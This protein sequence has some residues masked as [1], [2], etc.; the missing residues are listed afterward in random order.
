LALACNRNWTFIF[1]TFGEFVGVNFYLSMWTISCSQLLGDVCSSK[2]LLVE[3]EK[4]KNSRTP[5]RHTST[6]ALSHTRTRHTQAHTPCT[7]PWAATH[8]THAHTPCTCTH[9]THTPHA[10]HRRHTHAQHTM[11]ITRT[12]H[13]VQ[14]KKLKA[15]YHFS[16]SELLSQ[17]NT[18]PQLQRESTAPRWSCKLVELLLQSWFG[19]VGALLNTP[20]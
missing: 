8:Y 13:I 17:P 14:G 19:G 9:C 7:H 16:E 11:H 6:H 15:H 1:L 2:S 10:M 12:T 18:S 3:I 4:G 5:H 20:Y